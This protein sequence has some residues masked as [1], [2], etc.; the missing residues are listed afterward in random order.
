[1][2]DRVIS[3]LTKAGIRDAE[4]LV[5]VPKDPAMGDYAF[6]CFS[7]AREKKK[8]P[9][10]LAKEVA[11]LLQKD[12]GYTKIEAVGPYVNFFIDY[13]LY[14]RSLL[15]TIFKKKNAYGS[16][17]NGKKKKFMIEYSQPNTHKAF[18]VGHIRGT[19]LGESIARLHEYSGYSV[20]RAN[21]SGDTGMHIAK[22]M[23]AYLNFHKGETIPNDESYFASIYVEAVKKLTDNPEGEEAVAL[24]NRKLDARNDKM[25][26]ALWKKTRLQS[27]NSWKPIYKDLQVKFDVHFFE[28]EV[29]ASGKK[30]AQDLVKK[31]IAKISDDATIIDFKD[32]ALGV[33]VLLRSDGTVL[34]S[35]KDL[36]LAEL[37]YKTYSLNKSLVITSVEQ[38]LHFKQLIK[39]LEA[40]NFKGWERY[41]HMGYESVRLPEGKMSSR[42]GTNISYADFRNELMAEARRGLK[43][44]GVSDEKEL[45]KRSLAM[46]VAAMKY[47]MLK[48]DS[49]KV[50]IFN[51]E[52]ALRFEGDTGPY[53][54]YGYA[55][56]KSIV[57]KA[58]F[59]AGAL[60]NVKDISDSERLLMKELA[61]FPSVV[62]SAC[63]TYAPALVAHYAYGLTQQFN[64]FY[65]HEK[66]IGTPEEYYRLCLVYAFTLVL[67]NAL[68]ILGIPVLEE[69]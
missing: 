69:M 57:R 52:E 27:I 39:T 36:A 21:Y 64:E 17:T 28:S 9:M 48:Q 43:E 26:T 35:A 53:L 60:P 51:K 47:S 40:M 65:H 31:N 13:A 10:V 22:W 61:R 19:T 32:D 45:E 49:N 56:A 24:L 41:N 4:S 7:L 29:E 14:A 25:L 38:N 68:S 67:G 16:N 2:K 46:T 42:T 11:G 44:R 54:L 30:I 37:K 18:H 33:W 23:W 5:E 66:V 55:R 12:K 59:K 50:L 34:Y 58:G 6:P 15:E 62:E 3:S 1:M 20:I 63:Q 8:S